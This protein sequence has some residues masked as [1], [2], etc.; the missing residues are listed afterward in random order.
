MNGREKFIDDCTDRCSWQEG[1]GGHVDAFGQNVVNL[2][3]I[4]FWSSDTDLKV[5]LY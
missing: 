4:A 1:N 5:E 3:E 2:L